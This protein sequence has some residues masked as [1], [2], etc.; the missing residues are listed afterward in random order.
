MCEQ[1]R[2]WAPGLLPRPFEA[3]ST[4]PSGTNPCWTGCLAPHPLAHLA[5][6][7][8]SFAIRSPLKRRRALNLWWGWCESSA[9]LTHGMKVVRFPNSCRRMS[10]S[11]SCSFKIDKNCTQKWMCFFVV[12]VFLR[13][14]FHLG[15]NGRLYFFFSFFSFFVS[16]PCQVSGTAPAPPPPLLASWTAASVRHPGGPNMVCVLPEPVCP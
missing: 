16:D 11:P 14:S 2:L 1:N 8:L 7:C 10:E 15:W 4:P 6:S 3:A 12:L 9:C 13:P 5:R